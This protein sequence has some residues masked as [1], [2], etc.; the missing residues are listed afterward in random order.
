MLTDPADLFAFFDRHGLSHQTYAHPPIYTV[1][2]GRA[3][4]ARM[5]GG[6]T[7]NLFL[8]DKKGA[9]ILISAL[10]E[11]PVAL[12]ALH[13]RLGCGRLSFGKPDLLFEVLGVRPGSVTAFA[14][15]NDPDHRVRFVLDEALMAHDPVNFHPLTNT[16]TTAMPRRDFLRYLDHLGRPLEVMDLT[17]PA[18]VSE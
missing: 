12:K 8:K 3:L 16:A 10:G 9:L 1:E 15:M 18:S 2:E 6:H 11:T 4:K 5:P 14:L 17:V 7:K 13:H